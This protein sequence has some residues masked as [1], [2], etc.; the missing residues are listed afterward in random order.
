[1]DKFQVQ[2]ALL[3]NEPDNGCIKKHFF[4]HKHKLLSFVI[5]VQYL[6]PGVSFV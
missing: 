3:T 6:S 1:M 2:I 5:N 4:M